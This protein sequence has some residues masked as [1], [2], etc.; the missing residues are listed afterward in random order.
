MTKLSTGF[1][2]F[3]SIKIFV[4]TRISREKLQ[5]C[6]KSE[7][8]L[9]KMYSQSGS[10][11]RNC[12]VACGIPNFLLTKHR[13]PLWETAQYIWNDPLERANRVLCLN[14][15]GQFL[16]R[17]YVV[18]L[19]VCLSVGRLVCLSVCRSVCLSVGWSVRPSVCLFCLLFFIVT[20]G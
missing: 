17:F 6:Q 8:F 20:T 12:K 11:G 14:I 15:L 9:M 16:I 3:L 13:H 10:P 5:R 19:S 4:F 1:P 7:L 18:C 2:G